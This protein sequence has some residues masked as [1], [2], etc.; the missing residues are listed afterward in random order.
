MDEIVQH[1]GNEPAQSTTTEQGSVEQKIN[2]GVIRKSTTQSILKAASAASGI[3]FDSVE[4]LAATLARL[5]AQQASV[6]PNQ[7]SQ[8]SN[9]RRTTNSD[10][11][12]QFVNLK[13]DLHRK[14]QALR[15]R[16]LDS[17]IRTVM[18]DQFDSDL[19][20]YALTKVRSNIQWEDGSYQIV[21]QKG[22]VR[23]GEDGN[24]MTIKGLVNEVAKGNPKL[25]KISQQSSS[26]G[27]GLRPRQGM[28]GGESEMMPDY[29]TDPAGFNAWAQRNGL[30]RGIGLKGVSAQ[31]F[32]TSD[33]KRVM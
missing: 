10:L 29:A 26:N 8:E 16:E 15:E 24:P 27:S 28:F 22:Q 30:G 20:D 19:I 23:Y 4:T 6:A 3:E 11:Q 33:T 17:E 5:T 21:N 2:P 31:V 32:S 13:Q 25:L 9:S 1:D 7:P 12:E 14:E 18:G